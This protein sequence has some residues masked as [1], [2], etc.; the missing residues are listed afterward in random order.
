MGEIVWIVTYVAQV[1]LTNAHRPI[2]L[3]S[4]S[5]PISARVTKTTMLAKFST[6]FSTGGIAY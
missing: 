1:L 5:T 3:G 4:H 2:S 6:S